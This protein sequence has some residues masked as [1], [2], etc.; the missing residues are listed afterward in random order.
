[1]QPNS[2]NN[3]DGFLSNSSESQRHDKIINQDIEYENEP[4]FTESYLEQQRLMCS[5]LVSTQKK[6]H[7]EINE[8]YQTSK[9]PQKQMRLDL[10]EKYDEKMNANKIESHLRCGKPLSHSQFLRT[11]KKLKNL[12]FILFYQFFCFIY[13]H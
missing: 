6:Q 7:W 13:C 11:Y 8:F 3:V 5:D 4:T 2:A 12:V 10:C 1:M 9:D